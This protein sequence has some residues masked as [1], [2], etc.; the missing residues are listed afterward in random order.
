MIV[1]PEPAQRKQRA[2]ELLKLPGMSDIVS[3]FTFQIDRV[4]G[5]EFRVRF[6]KESFAELTLDEPPPLGKDAGPNP[7]RLLAAAVGN[8]LAASLTFCLQKS[9]TPIEGLRAE[10][11]TQLV[12]NEQKRLRV[13]A[14]QVT[15]RP[16]VPGGAAALEQCLG[17]FE[18]FCVVTQSVRE[19]FP[20]Q[21]QVEAETP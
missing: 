10:V 16:R 12:R 14:I 21:V 11:K 7:T 6:D 17:S 3:E 2:Q 9:R 5:Y 15:L 19:G 1:A 4:D 20:I 13:G 18:D 8:C